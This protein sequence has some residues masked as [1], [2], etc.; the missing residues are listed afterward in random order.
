M[1]RMVGITT[2]IC[3]L[4][5]VAVSQNS[6]GWTMRMISGNQLK[7][8]SDVRLQLLTG[9]TLRYR[10]QNVEG[11]ALVDSVESISQT[12]GRGKSFEVFLQ[13]L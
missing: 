6:A 2:S 8:L 11:W 10:K 9:D 12:K 4:F 5:S 7:E 3:L 13:A 1:K